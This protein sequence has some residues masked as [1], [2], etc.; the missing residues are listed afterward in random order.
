MLLVNLLVPQCKTRAT[1]ELSAYGPGSRKTN[2]RKGGK[3]HSNLFHVVAWQQGSN[4]EVEP[5]GVE[6]FPRSGQK[7]EPF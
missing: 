6:A 7:D 4:Q 1:S 2:S 3:L 5:K